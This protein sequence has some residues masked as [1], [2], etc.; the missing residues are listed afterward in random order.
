MQI[1]KNILIIFVK[2]FP[3]LQATNGYYEMMSFA[4]QNTMIFDDIIDDDEIIIDTQ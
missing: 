1:I 2:W 4:I 3:K